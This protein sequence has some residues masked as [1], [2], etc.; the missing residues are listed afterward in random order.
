MISLLV[1]IVVIALVVWLIGLLP[2]PSPF[3]MI[4]KVIAIIIVIVLILRFVGIVII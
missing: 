3:P 1:S 2:L 4:I